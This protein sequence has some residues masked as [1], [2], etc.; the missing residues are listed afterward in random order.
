VVFSVAMARSSIAFGL[1]KVG[2]V[3]VE[4]FVR[5]AGRHGAAGRANY[6]EKW[7]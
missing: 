3:D 1:V 5:V 7:A 6:K 2:D 4:V